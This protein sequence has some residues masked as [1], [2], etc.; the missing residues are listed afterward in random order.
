MAFWTENGVVREKQIFSTSNIWLVLLRLNRKGNQFPL[1]LSAKPK[2]KQFPLSSEVRK[3]NFKKYENRIS[4]STKTELQEVRESNCNKTD[5]I[6]TDF[7]K[8]DSIINQASDDAMDR[9][10]LQISYDELCADPAVDRQCLDS[11]VAVMA[12]T[13]QSS[14]SS[15]R[16]NRC[17]RPAMAVKK[18][19]CSLQEKHIR[20]VLQAW[21]NNKAVVRNVRQYILTALYNAPD[22]LALYQSQHASEKDSPSYDLDAYERESWYDTMESQDEFDI[23]QESIACTG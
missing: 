8:T 13:L 14:F 6:K 5:L 21:Q 17:T 10:K 7:T 16:V 23:E 9:V 3:S 15:I 11:L 2:L 22:T 20:Y 1:F 12:E 4:R 18:K 19:L